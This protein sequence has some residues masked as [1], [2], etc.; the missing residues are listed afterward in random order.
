M[1]YLPPAEA[2]WRR[3]LRFFICE[4]CRDMS[5]CSTSSTIRDLNCLY[6]CLD[7]FC[8]ILHSLSNI[9]LED[10]LMISVKVSKITWRRPPRGGS[11]GRSCH[12]TPRPGLMLTG[13]GSCLLSRCGDSR[14]WWRTGGDRISPGLTSSPSARSGRW[15]SDSSA[16]RQLR[17]GC[18]GTGCH[19]F[20]HFVE[21][22]LHGFLLPCISK[23]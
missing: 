22:I 5:V 9:V 6:S 19:D 21:F 20:K 12:Y 1:P 23:F 8:R 11:R 2:V 4:K 15:S 7:K 16:T 14:G 3:F 17:A 10:W 13:C 18:C